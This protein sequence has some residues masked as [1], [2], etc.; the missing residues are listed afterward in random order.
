M[1][2]IYLFQLLMLGLEKICLSTYFLLKPKDDIFLTHCDF[3]L[4]CC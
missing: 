1:Y 3:S 2:F 4:P